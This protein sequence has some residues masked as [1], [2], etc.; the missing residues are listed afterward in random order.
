MN[1][2]V[3]KLI[4]RK[5]TFVCF[6]VNDM[7]FTRSVL[8][9]YKNNNRLILFSSNWYSTLISVRLWNFKNGGSCKARFLPLNQHARRKF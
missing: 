7:V 3:V 4:A 8:T 2:S 6:D 5:R 9:L 1:K